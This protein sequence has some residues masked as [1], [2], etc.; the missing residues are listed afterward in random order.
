MLIYSKLHSKSCDY[1]YEFGLLRWKSSP[2]YNERIALSRGYVSRT[3]RANHSMDRRH[4]ISKKKDHRRRADTVGRLRTAIML[5][6]AVLKNIND[7]FFFSDRREKRCWR[8][9]SSGDEH[10]AASRKTPNGRLF[11]I[12]IQYPHFFSVVQPP[13][14]FRHFP[15]Q[16][17]LK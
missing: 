7:F 17:F 1:L 16:H 6:F 15:R 10:K 2:Q 14:D 3:E 8:T 11:P 4:A 5:G 12:N 13:F 9:Y